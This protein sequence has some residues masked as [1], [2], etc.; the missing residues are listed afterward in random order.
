MHVHDLPP[1]ILCGMLVLIF[2]S[3]LR[4]TAHS[5]LRF[6]VFGWAF[7]F[8]H[9]AAQ[10]LA[11]S[12]HGPAWPTIVSLDALLL[13]GT[14]FLLSL[15]PRQRRTHLSIGGAA[16]Y[17]FAGSGYLAMVAAGLSSP[18][19]LWTLFSL[20]A[21]GLAATTLCAAS[22]RDLLP[23]LLGLAAIGAAGANCFT[24]QPHAVAGIFTL[25]SGIYLACGTAYFQRFRRLSTG[26]LTVIIGFAAWGMVWP[27]ASALAHYAPAL[28]VPTGTWSLPKLFVAIGMILTVLEDEAKGLAREAERIRT[29]YDHSQCGLFVTGLDGVVRD[30]N[31]S[32][33]R[34]G[35]FESS[36]SLIGQ[37]V[38]QYYQ[39]P[40]YRNLLLRELLE[41]GS[42]RNRELELVGRDGTIFTGLISARLR[43]DARGRPVEIEGA[44]LD[45]TEHRQLHQ[46][47]LWQSRH[48]ALT[49]LPNRSAIQDQLEAALA[50]AAARGTQLALVSIDVDNFKLVNDTHGHAL[51]DAFL[52]SLACHI[53]SAIS[54]SDLFGRV[55]G[56]E[57]LLAFPGVAS[58]AEA[59]ARLDA[60][61]RS[62]H[63]PLNIEDRRL[64]ASVSA[65]VAVY[66]A[67]A[68]SV[69]T[70]SSHAVQ[71]LSRAKALGRNQYQF[72]SRHRDLIQDAMEIEGLLENGLAHNAFVLHY[73]P[74]VFADGTLYGTEAL[75][76]FRHPTRGLLPPSSFLSIAERNGLLHNVGE[77]VLEEACRQFHRWVRQGLEPMTVS[78][79]VSAAQFNRADY[80][81]TVERVLEKQN[82]PPEFLELELTESLL[83]GDFQQTV[84][85][86][87]SLK[88][89]GIRIAVDD[90]GTGYSS[91]SYLH[92]LPIDVL[93][94]DRSFVEKVDEPGGTKPIIEAI[95]ALARSLQV[96]VVAEGIETELQRSILLDLGTHRMQGFLFSHPVPAEQIAGLSVPTR[97]L[98]MPPRPSAPVIP[99][100]V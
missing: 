23:N 11:S 42:I 46:K 14:A 4:R 30:C 26:T 53:A 64:R 25:L 95:I 50:S 89:L 20:A 37:N 93:K 13:A 58:E 69:A 5:E 99:I 98:R 80:C 66:P 24:L 62:L 83:I 38:N 90:F 52:R 85:Q 70:L 33:A 17:A 9:F 28:Q 45:V 88:S 59:A 68:Q 74:Q 1:V 75:L 91:L 41:T 48:D 54:P 22:R 43:T 96:M 73:Q 84:Q 32:M 12:T 81:A 55:S 40:G 2:A 51:G 10:L 72:Y 56:D 94:I 8:V 87:D 29:L 15:F 97:A 86:M 57:F 36:R 67:D 63:A 76:R 100:R 16:L 21:A 3:I 31:E 60:V 19:L 49:G 47:L 71:A 27:A 79:N 7:I 61:L 18:S 65:G 82:M 35:H 44:L 78:V 39:D 77:W 6:W 92:R 34:M